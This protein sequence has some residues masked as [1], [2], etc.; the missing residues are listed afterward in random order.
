MTPVAMTPFSVGRNT[1]PER[2][3]NYHCEVK[4]T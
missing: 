3:I 4:R 1:T 2:N